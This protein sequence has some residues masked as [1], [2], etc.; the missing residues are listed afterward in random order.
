MPNCRRGQAHMKAEFPDFC[1][2]Q[3]RALASICLALL[4]DVKIPQDCYFV[5]IEVSGFRQ[6]TLRTVFCFCT[7]RSRA[8][9][10]AGSIPEGKV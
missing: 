8:G 10:L 1:P 3:P 9:L 7:P 5:G 2:A 6:A 4:F